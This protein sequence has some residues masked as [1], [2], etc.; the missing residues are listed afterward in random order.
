MVATIIREGEEGTLPT[1]IWKVIW[2]NAIEFE[3]KFDPGGIW[4]VFPMTPS[5][6]PPEH[7]S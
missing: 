2:D 4:S 7:S 5:R 1:E 6:A 3:K